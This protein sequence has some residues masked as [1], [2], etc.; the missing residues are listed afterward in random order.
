MSLFSAVP[1]SSTVP[2]CQIVCDNF[3]IFACLVRVLLKAHNFNLSLFPAPWS[4][5]PNLGFDWPSAIVQRCYTPDLCIYIG[6]CAVFFLSKHQ[7][8]RLSTCPS[9]AGGEPACMQFCLIW[10]D[11]QLKDLRTNPTWNNH[12]QSESDWVCW[13]RTFL[14]NFKG[15]APSVA[16]GLSIHLGEDFDFDFVATARTLLI[17]VRAGHNRFPFTEQPLLF[18]TASVAS[19]PRFRAGRG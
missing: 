13:R 5:S 12:Q 10:R 3:R 2:A 9:W 19:G 14:V 16:S 15:V 4:R 6:I 17:D 8:P 18:S 11:R 7:C 1:R